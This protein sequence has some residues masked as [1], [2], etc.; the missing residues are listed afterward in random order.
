MKNKVIA[1]MAIMLLVVAISSCATSRKFGCP[2]VS[3]NETKTNK[4]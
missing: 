1:F 3:K 4:V 2:T